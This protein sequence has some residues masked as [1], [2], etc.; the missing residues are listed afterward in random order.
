MT[1]S[2]TLS[3]LL[4]RAQIC[5]PHSDVNPWWAGLIHPNSNLCY[6]STSKV[7]D[8]IRMLVFKHFHCKHNALRIR[9][10][11]F[12]FYFLRLRWDWVHLVRRSL[13]GLSYT[14]DRWWGWSSR[15]NENCQGKPKYSEKTCP[16]ATLF[17][18]N[19][20]CTHLSLKPGHGGEKSAANPLIY[21][22]AYI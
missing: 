18:T 9:Q 20:T 7:S 22:M 19:R 2:R 1:R 12:F 17:T 8:L 14:D 10:F 16:S 5:T 15:W 4:H 13:F 21:G 3:S 11:S 6:K